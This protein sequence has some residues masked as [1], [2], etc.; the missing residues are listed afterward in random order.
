MSLPIIE[1]GRFAGSKQERW[2]AGLLDNESEATKE[3]WR[4]GSWKT[5]RSLLDAYIYI[6]ISRG[7]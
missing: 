6:Y 7:Q 4:R 3:W 5:D 1:S 2:V